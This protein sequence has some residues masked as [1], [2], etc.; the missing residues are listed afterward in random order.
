MT[1]RSEK[2]LL[3]CVSF[4]LGVAC[5]VLIWSLLGNQNTGSQQAISTSIDEAVGLQPGH[6]HREP[7]AERLPENVPEPPP[8]ALPGSKSQ[9][10]GVA[11]SHVGLTDQP[12]FRTVDPVPVEPEPEKKPVDPSDEFFQQGMIP[13]IRIT[14][15]EKEEEQL[16]RDLRRY[17]DVKFTEN[18]M[19]EYKH[20][21][22]KLKGAAGS[23]RELGDRPALTLALRKKGERFHGLEKFHLNN[24]VQDETYLHELSASQ[25]CQA[26]GVPAART[27][28]ARVW[29]NGRDLG[30]YVL[31]EGLDKTFLKRHFKDPDGNL[32]EGPF[33]ADIDAALEKESGTGPDDRSDLKE[34]ITACREEDQ[35]KRWTLVEE[36]VAIDEFINFAALELMMCHWDGYCNNRNNYRVYFHADDKRACFIPHG[37]DQMFEDVN[38]GVLNVPGTLVANAVLQNPE[39]QVRFRRRVRELLS[40]FSP[41]K[42]HTRIDAAHTR[43]RPVLEAIHPDRARNFD[44]KVQGFKD[45]V[46]GRRQAILSQFPPEPIAFNAEGWA[47]AENWT[48]KP[49]GDAKLEI[50]QEG[51][52]QVLALTPGP[53]HQIQASFRTT[54]RLARGSYRLEGKV[55]PEGVVSTPEEKGT[56]AGV[57]LGG[58]MRQNQAIGTADW[59]TVSHEFEIGQDLQEVELV[60]EL[61]STAGSAL[62]DLQSLRVY[63]LK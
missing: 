23:F 53:S 61:R 60:A 45:R 18:G 17:V 19:T 5:P 35:A 27:T 11:A 40:L 58:G 34:L 6:S 57:R 48:A 56:G 39:V 31:K 22:M 32:Y 21:K 24:S 63:K 43:I 52:K 15:K 30:F 1:N 2:I 10:I 37:M 7:R 28:H 51:D 62:F 55:K 54:I 12:P 33:V 41:D 46:A 47:L 16:R 13:E 14:L 36:K 49:Q 26:A 38:F 25:L 20:V 8:D 44:N 59:T 42:L 50:R 9:E 29:L 4:F 3:S